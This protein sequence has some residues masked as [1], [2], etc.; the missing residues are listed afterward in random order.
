MIS[1][2][3]TGKDIAIYIQGDSLYKLGSVY[4]ADDEMAKSDYI[5]VIE[6]LSNEDETV[7]YRLFGLAAGLIEGISPDVMSSLTG[8]IKEFD[9]YRQST[10]EK[11]AD[12]EVLKKLLLAR[13]IESYETIISGTT[14]TYQ[15]L[16]STFMVDANNGVIKHNYSPSYNF[17]SRGNAGEAFRA[18]YEVI[19][20]IKEILQPG[21]DLYLHSVEEAM[22]GEVGT[23]IFNIGYMAGNYPVLLK[24]GNDISYPLVIQANSQN[25]ISYKWTLK[26]IRGADASATYDINFLNL[27]QDLFITYSM[28]ESQLK[29]DNAIEGYVFENTYDGSL[30]PS[31][32]IDTGSGMLC[33]QM[34]ER[35]AN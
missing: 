15:T 22:Y 5:D 6:E 21:T 24:N 10:P 32:L 35:Q 9:M 4:P 23:Y 26:E 30:L 16:N 20:T 27:L 19:N 11:I 34:R 31:L 33:L 8:S 13:H 18:A 25:V 29:M 3:G 1:L 2:E 7:D 28:D 17:Q 14:I 12:E